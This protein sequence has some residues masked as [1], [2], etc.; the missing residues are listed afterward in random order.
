MQ[1]TPTLFDFRVEQKNECRF[2]YILPFSATKALVEFTVFSDNI[3]EKREYEFYLKNYLAEVLKIENYKILETE[4]GVIPMSDEPHERISRRKNR[5]E[6]AQRA[7]MSNLRP[8]TVLN[9]RKTFCRKLSKDLENSG[10][11]P[12]SKIQNPKLENLS[13]FGFARCFT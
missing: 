13:R 4:T 2:I 5:S 8:A 7:A 6:S 12:K 1:T 11:N 10:T 3:L 9:E